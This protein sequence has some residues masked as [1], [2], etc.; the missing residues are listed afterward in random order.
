MPIN[1]IWHNCLNRS[2]ISGGRSL[3]DLSISILALLG[4]RILMCRRMRRK[5]NKLY[6]SV[7]VSG[8]TDIAEWKKIRHT[9]ATL[10]GVCKIFFIQGLLFICAFNSRASFCSFWNVFEMYIFT[11]CSVKPSIVTTRV[12]ICRNSPQA[13]RRAVYT[14]VHIGRSMFIFINTDDFC[15]SVGNSSNPS[16][17]KHI[18]SPCLLVISLSTSLLIWSSNISSKSLTSFAS[19]ISFSRKGNKITAW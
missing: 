8:N 1:A 7:K 4:V 13:S 5:T 9:I 14:S 17:I 2:E 18:L 19:C 16:K 3:S 12:A 6:N 10:I 15:K 11:D